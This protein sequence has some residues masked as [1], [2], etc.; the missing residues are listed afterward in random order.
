MPY[1]RPPLSKEVL[2]GDVGA[3]PGDAADRRGRLALDWLLGRRATGLDLAARAVELDDAERV[4]FD[5]LVI[6]TGATPRTLPGTAGLAGV[7]TLRTL[8]DC[9]AIRAALDRTPGRV[10]VVGAGFIG[11]EVAATCRGRN[12]STSPCVEALPVPLGRVL[13]DEMGAVCGDVHRD[14][15]VDLRLGV[16]VAGFEG[17]GRVERVLL[18]DGS[19]DRR[20]PRGGRRRRHAQHRRGSTGRVSRSTTASCATRRASAAPGVVAAGDVARWPNRLFGEVMR[21]EHWD[22]AHRAGRA[23]RAHAAR[24]R[25]P[26]EPFTPVPWFW[27]DQYDRKI[28]LAGRSTPHDEVRIV[29]GSVEERKFAALYRR[30]DRVVGVLGFNRPRVVMQYRRLIADGASWDDA[31]AAAAA[32][33]VTRGG[34]TVP[35]QAC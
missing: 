27:S 31:L 10:V 13:G 22:N 25:R 34:V 9:L 23:R 33:C 17:G 7:H 4:P 21:V 28:Q 29:D 32:A 19:G 12:G 6:A 20:R 1:D 26:D 3:R 8:D 30:G 15:G 11:A 5:G 24:R 18:A 16:G 2:A 35:R 14:H